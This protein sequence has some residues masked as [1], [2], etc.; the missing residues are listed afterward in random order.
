MTVRDTIV[1]NTFWYAVVTAIGILSGLLTS[2][3]L[4]R[5][6]GPARMG[7]YSYLLW[8]LRM[9]TALATLGYAV[10]TVRYT[11]AA[12][13]QQR[14][15]VAS[16]LLHL[17]VRR[18]L[19]AAVLVA[20]A[21]AP[22]VL[23]LAPAGFRWPLLALLVGLVPITLEAIYANAAYGAQ[24][25]DLTTQ[26]S[27]LKMTLEFAVMV[28]LVSAGAGILGIVVGTLAVTTITCLLQRRQALALY[29]ER[30][31]PIPD[32]TRSELN[33]YVLSLSIVAV[34]DT[35]VWD[36]SEIF[37]LGLYASSAEI[38]FYSLAF[39]L[40]G[41]VMLAPQVIAG[42]LLPVLAELH[43]GGD[44]AE[45]GHVYRATIRAVTLVGAP[46]VVIG[47]AV[48]PGMIRL[49]YGRDYLPVA[50]LLVPMLAVSLV[51]VMR[52]VAW[53]ALRAT[54]DRRWALHATWT[55][56]AVNIGAAA[57]LIP[58]W[59]T[60]GAVVANAVAQLLASAIAFVGVAVRC[61][62]GW[63]GLDLTRVGAASVVGF[64]A[65]W[66]A[67]HGFDDALDLTAAASAGA[68][69]FVVV[70]ALLGVFGPRERA[71]V[72]GRLS[73]LPR[74]V[75]V[76]GTAGILAAVLALIYAA[77]IVRLSIVW[78]TVPYY[79]YGFL[80]P[81]FSAWAA[82]E[83][84]RRLD[85]R[86][87]RWDRRWLIVIAA[88]LGFLTAGEALHSL[89]LSALSIPVTLAGLGL[90]ALGWPSFRPLTFPLA[91]LAFIAPLPDA[92]IAAISPALQRAAAWFAAVSLRI[93]GV[94]AVRADLTIVLP[95][96]TIEVTEAC[97]GLRFLLAMVVVGTAFAW[98]SQSG[99]ARR[100]A[101]V[102]LAVAV[103][104]VANL[105][106]VAGTGF[107]AYHWGPA[108]ASGFYHVVYGKLVYVAMLLPFALGVLW[109]RRAQTSRHRVRALTRA[110]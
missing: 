26:V 36:R 24:R 95:T 43:G 98:A 93:A 100:V 23:A 10:A 46:L 45:F 57:V 96:L 29:P 5:G 74:W 88:G 15:G 44:R 85:R 87:R 30:P 70:A 69:M 67:A 19:A 101:V 20:G 21:L 49:L 91:F 7:D 60:W 83:A 32:A 2:I 51:G 54:G 25:Y 8:V 4:A 68:A 18:Q 28:T 13:A 34:L 62:C 99:A 80:V 92:V 47:A 76:A 14:D 53:S 86:P 61:R 55:A 48:G 82:W 106:R 104:V 90:F 42:P 65:A 58:R 56:A 12:R 33:R 94:P 81:V 41:R 72:S 71:L 78:F 9:M 39:G 22:A 103:A 63:P 79:S 84:G 73:R 89:T 77:V 31:A 11:A 107:I 37:F 75:R 102:V 110:T 27:A 40:A 3:V 6:L 50:A 105:L 16:A 1:R 66:A 52:Q 64:A 38:A 109:L 17:F 35:I 108:A 97:N 59:G